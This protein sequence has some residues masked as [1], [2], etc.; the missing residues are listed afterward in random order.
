[1]SRLNR[2]RL[3]TVAESLPQRDRELVRLVARL[4]LMSH[5]QL[6]RVLTPSGATPSAASAAR[7]TRRVLARL[8]DLGM[9][10]RLERRVGGLRAG[11]AG[12]VYYLGPTGQRLLAYWDGHGIVRGR[13]R[14]EPGG[15][16]VRHRLAVSD[17]YVQLLAT[18]RTGELDLLNFDAEPDCWRRS[19]DGF[20]GVMLLK[21]D[22]YV[23]LGI[24]AYEERCFVEV[25]LATES[26]IVIAAKLRTYL[27]Y[28][29][30]GT[31]QTAHGVFPRV[32]WLT[33]SERRR[34]AL[35]GV[36]ARLPAEHWQLFTV[37]R[38]D[39]AVDVL[40]GHAAAVGAQ[41]DDGGRS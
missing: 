39:Q 32:V 15:R 23:R 3:L 25:D 17:L 11:S 30:S 31:E 29:L 21:P 9:L 28:F 14:P 24:G 19:V 1:M 8:S 6:H 36:I 26:R 38:L 2:G 5:A 27:A 22:V 37:G 7:S 12:F 41:A 40:S 34:E 35:V 13:V 10:A 18:E 33:D 16:Y 4:R 20:G